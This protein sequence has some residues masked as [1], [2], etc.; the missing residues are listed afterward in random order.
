MEK[1]RA[2]FKLKMIWVIAFLAF[3][4][5]SFSQSGVTNWNQVFSGPAPVNS[6]AYGNGTFVGVGWWIAFHF[7]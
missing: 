4:A 6:I 7:P 5:N 2:A 3:A 1:I